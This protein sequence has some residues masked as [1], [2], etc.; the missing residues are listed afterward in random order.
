MRLFGGTRLLT[1]TGPGGCGKTRLAI[2][3]AGELGQRF[4][5]GVAFVDL[6]NVRDSAM[7]GSAFGE[8][9]GLTLDSAGA[10]ARRIADSRFLLLV[11]NAEHVVDAVAWLVQDLLGVC[12]NLGVLVTSRE[13]LNIPGEISWRVPS[14]SLPPVNEARTLAQLATY[15]SVQLFC[16]RAAEQAPGFRLTTQNASLVTDICRR[17]DGI[18][19]ALELAAARVRSL[20]LSEIVTRLGD[21]VRLLTGGSRTAIARHQTL[22][23]ALDWSHELLVPEERILLRRLTLFVD[24]F[25]LEAAVAVCSG[26]DLDGA[27]V[28]EV[29][30]SLVDKSLVAT[31]RVADGS[32]RY[33]LIEAIRQYGREKLVAAGEAGLEEVHARHYCRL[34]MRLGGDGDLVQRSQRLAA[35]YENVRQALDWCAAEDPDLETRVVDALGWF[36]RA[37][38]LVREALLRV[39]AALENDRLSARDRADLLSEAGAWSQRSA[40]LEAATAYAAAA[41]EMLGQFDDPEVVSRI[42]DLRG[43][44]RAEAGDLEGAERDFVEGLRARAGREASDDMINWANNLAMTRLLLG[45]PQDALPDAELALEIQRQLGTAAPEVFHTHGAALMGVGRVAEAREQFLTGLE[46]AADHANYRAASSLIDGL[47]SQLA[48]GQPLRAMTLLGAAEACRRIEGTGR[49]LHPDPEAVEAERRC[50][51]VLGAAGSEAAFGRGL[52]LGWREVLEMARGEDAEPQSPLTARKR[53]IAS[54]VAAGL[55]NK[56]IARRLAISERT[57]DA[58]LEQLRNQ[59]G[60]HNRAQV[61][62]WAAEQARKAGV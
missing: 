38:G 51:L 58:H 6:A 23:A 62:V 29:L 21:S 2:E 33:S 14:L 43:I 3:L 18:P 5:D 13:L 27:A 22:R 41:A 25:D 9:V 48:A 36:W 54:L 46:V 20:S 28:P 53:Q 31:D 42:H 45:R 60:L 15:D 57:V 50:R 35:D 47:A 30:A 17:L 59:L 56:E 49:R 61:A 26:P 44:L 34:V 55:S 1:L 24:T 40:D 37:R 19:L 12:P 52:Q 39:C 10:T 16:A 32:L 11:D 4:G 8:A 7:V